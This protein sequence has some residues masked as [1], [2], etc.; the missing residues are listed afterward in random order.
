MNDKK[1]FYIF[2]DIDGVFNSYGWAHHVKKNNLEKEGFSA[3]FCSDNL[4]IFNKMLKEIRS[5]NFEPKIILSSDWRKERFQEAIDLFNKYGIEYDGEYDK[6]GNAHIP[7]DKEGMKRAS[8]IASYCEANDIDLKDSFII[9][10]DKIPEIRRYIYI[11]HPSHFLQ[12]SGEGG[13]GLNESNFK[14]FK[15]NN[16]PQIIELSNQDENTI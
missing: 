5:N 4:K 10:D 1:D 15:E 8:E 16:L 14:T 11:L 2:L 7:P 3:E 12:T 6:T 9:I 13:T